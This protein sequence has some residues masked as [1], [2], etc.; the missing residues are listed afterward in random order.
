MSEII[1]RCV[2]LGGD[3][4]GDDWYDFGVVALGFHTTSERLSALSI[5]GRPFPE[6]PL[7]CRKC[8]PA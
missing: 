4:A 2:V 7:L 5:H 3:V 8:F 1:I 6:E